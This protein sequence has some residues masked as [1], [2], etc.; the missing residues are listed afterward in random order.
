MNIVDSYNLV[1]ICIMVVL[2]IMFIL[3]T[4]KG[5]LKSLTAVASVTVGGLV[6]YK[7]YP[8]VQ[9]FLSKIS[10]LD[11]NISMILSIIIVFI[12]V[13]IAFIII[14]RILDA[15]LAVTRLSWLDRACGAVI[16][17]AAGFLIV[18]VAVQLIIIGI[19]ESSI[20]KTSKLM[21][22]VD[23]LTWRGLAYAPKPARDQV[24]LMISKWK[25]FQEA[26]LSAPRQN[27]VQLKVPSVTAEIQNER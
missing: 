21:Q 13:Q 17:I 1:D 20:V 18:A 26:P 16:G 11:P 25:G 10:S 14:R 5:F 27:S 24:Q 12:G 3:G 9:P 23:R 15:F 2:S 19:P 4:W 6:S 8:K 22:P 7:Y